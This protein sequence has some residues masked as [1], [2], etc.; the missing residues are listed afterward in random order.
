[1]VGLYEAKDGIWNN[2]GPKHP[3]EDA[4]DYEKDA[5]DYINEPYFFQVLQNKT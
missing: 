5:S 2:D 4:I 3:T 1:V